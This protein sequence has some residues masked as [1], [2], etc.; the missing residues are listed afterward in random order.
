MHGDTRLAPWNGLSTPEMQLLQT[1]FWSAG[2]SRH[3]M[4]ERLGFSRSKANALIA[5]LLDQGLLAET[6]P[7][8]SSG[9]RRAEHLRLHDGLGVLVGVDVGATSV[10]VAIL[11]PDLS[12][13]GHP[14][15]F[16][17]GD[18]AVM[19]NDGRPVPGVAQG[20][21]QSGPQAARNVLRLI[22]GRSTRPFRYVNKGDAATIGRYRALFQFP[23]FHL[24]GKPAWWFWLFLH[25][26][27]LAG[28]RNRLFV[29]LEW[30]Y[31]YLTFRRGVRLIAGTELRTPPA[32][33]EWPVWRART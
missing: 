7:R 12:V 33:S 18:Q 3:G 17:V 32:T 19:M 22:Q 20:A 8:A 4:A 30:G 23:G 13:P 15:V 5:G 27:Y 6:G 14:E 28:F 26:M 31:M 11:Q 29:L 10:D 16:V 1:T 21:M 24:T 2:G 9:G 25:I